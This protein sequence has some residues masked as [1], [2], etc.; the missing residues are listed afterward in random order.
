MTKKMVDGLTPE[1]YFVQESKKEQ[2]S[3]Y[4]SSAWEY[5]IIFMDEFE[6]TFG[7]AYEI[8]KKLIKKYEKLGQLTTEKVKTTIGYGEVNR[9]CNDIWF[10]WKPEFLPQLQNALNNS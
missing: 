2:A 9:E 4:D 5:R 7:W 1:Q 6:L 8:V 3:G 10:K